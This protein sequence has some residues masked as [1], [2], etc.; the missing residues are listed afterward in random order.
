MARE[1]EPDNFH[2]TADRSG[3]SYSPARKMQ[4]L[5]E[6]LPDTVSTASPFVAI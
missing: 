5:G 2:F 3:R 1:L 4:S 6:T